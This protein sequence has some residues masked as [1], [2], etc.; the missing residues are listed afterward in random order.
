MKRVPC[1]YPRAQR[2]KVA[3]SDCSSLLLWKRVGVVWEL[4][5]EWRWMQLQSVVVARGDARRVGACWLLWRWLAG[6]RAARLS[7][8]IIEELPHKAS[9]SNERQVEESKRVRVAERVG[10][11]SE[12]Q[13]NAKGRQRPF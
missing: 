11:K 2:I 1:I 3:Q 10:G 5:S 8:R 6:I 13:W 12:R 9:R 7:V 4:T